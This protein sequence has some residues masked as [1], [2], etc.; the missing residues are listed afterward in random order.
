MSYKLQVIGYKLQVT[1][2]RLQVTGHKLQVK[3]YRHRLHWTGVYRL[4][5]IGYLIKIIGKLFV[6]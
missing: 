4:E 3:G 5:F 1:S 6:V 2:Y